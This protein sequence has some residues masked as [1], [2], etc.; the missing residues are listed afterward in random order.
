[1]GVRVVQHLD[2]RLRRTACDPLRT[3]HRTGALECRSG[4]VPARFGLQAL[5]VCVLT[6]NSAAQAREFFLDAARTAQRGGV[7]RA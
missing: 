1:L 4:T 2:N 7:N 3:L 5:D 6:R